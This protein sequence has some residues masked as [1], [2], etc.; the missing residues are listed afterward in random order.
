[1]KKIKKKRVKYAGYK[2]TLTALSKLIYE[3]SCAE[4]DK[5]PG[6]VWDPMNL[7]IRSATIISDNKMK[8]EFNDKVM[9]GK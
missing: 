5:E 6:V 9:K 8:Q 2:K 1:M 4:V 3:Y 7:L